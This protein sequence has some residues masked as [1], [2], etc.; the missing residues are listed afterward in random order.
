MKNKGGVE[1]QTLKTG[2]KCIKLCG[3]HPGNYHLK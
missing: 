1:S 3:I 2:F